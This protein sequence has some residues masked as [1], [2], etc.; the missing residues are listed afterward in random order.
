MRERN[1]YAQWKMAEGKYINVND[2]TDSHLASA[3]KYV[4]QRHLHASGL[5]DEIR[6]KDCVYNGRSW[7]SWIDVFNDERIRRQAAADKIPNSTGVELEVRFIQYN[8]QKG[9]TTVMFENGDIV[10]VKKAA[11]TKY[12]EYDA[13]TAAV[14]KYMFGSQR[15][16]KKI[17]ETTTTI[18]KKKQ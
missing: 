9:I 6:S 8:E 15:N 16:V 5:P 2:M 11:G 12:C 10:M 1:T 7:R 14:T 4:Q 13:F 3:L 18:K 17:V